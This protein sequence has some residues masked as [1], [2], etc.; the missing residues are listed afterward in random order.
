MH[1]GTN[2]SQFFITTVPTPH[3]DDKHVVFGEVLSG[4]S[5]VRAIENVHTQSDKPTTEVVITECGEL[6]ANDAVF[7]ETKTT[8][9]L[10]DP[11]EDFPEDETNN[12][13]PLTAQKVLEIAAACKDFGNTAFKSGDF[14]VA[15][16]KY[17]KGLRYLNEDPDLDGE[18]ADTKARM[19]ALRVTLNSNAALMNLKL[20][21]WDECVRAA[22]AALK[23]DGISDKDRAKALYRRGVAHTRNRDDDSALKDLEGAK[24]LAPSDA[25]IT[26][27]LASVKKAA[28]DR[29][30]KEKAAYK[31]FFA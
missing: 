16:D 21:A 25:G 27:E 19:N 5:V 10:G 31:K 15:L 26:N 6:T 7:P 17:E 1:A 8:D 12:D 24:K 2:G 20:Q 22:S 9:A 3:L 13:Q 23:V 29:L 18:P 4:K 11:Y 14:S 30:A 28:A